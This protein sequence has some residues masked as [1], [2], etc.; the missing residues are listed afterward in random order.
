M[1]CNICV[2]RYALIF[3]SPPLAKLHRFDPVKLRE[4]VPLF[5]SSE[6]VLPGY[7]RANAAS[8]TDI[9]IASCMFTSL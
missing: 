5:T 9:I 3:I 1:C 8:Q 4:Y 7:A 2:Y 6:D